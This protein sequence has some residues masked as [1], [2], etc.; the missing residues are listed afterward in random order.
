MSGGSP[1]ER[2]GLT[3]AFV[4]RDGTI[5]AKAPEGD[6]VKSWA[7]FRFLPGAAE[8]LAA[9]SAAGLRVVVVTNQRGIALGRMSERDLADIHAR[10]LEEAG[11]AGARVDAVY[12]CPHHEGECDC[13]KPA[14]GMFERA[15][16]ELPGL[17]F[18][19]SVTIGDSDRDMGA[20]RA[21][22]SRL[23]RIAREDD[24]AVDRVAPSLAVAAGWLVGHA[25]A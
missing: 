24:P 13:R 9:L 16:R 17:D 7:E 3:T 23:V 25:P 6:Y 4:D 8:A 10:M 19:R 1:V 5:N 18:S 22:G 2:W 11:A 21:I 12:H 14:T 20:G 15:R